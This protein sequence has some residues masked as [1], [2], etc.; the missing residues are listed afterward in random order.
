MRINRNSMERQVGGGSLYPAN[1]LAQL[2]LLM[3]GN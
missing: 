1:R 2:L 3:S